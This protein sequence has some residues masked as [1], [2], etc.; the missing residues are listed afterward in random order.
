ME[1][2]KEYENIIKRYINLAKKTKNTESE[3]FWT[4]A[5]SSLKRKDNSVSGVIDSLKDILSVLEISD[6]ESPL[7]TLSLLLELG[8]SSLIIGDESLSK[9]CFEISSKISSEKL[10]K[11]LDENARLYQ[12]KGEKKVSLKI[13][14]LNLDSV[15]KRGDGLK[16]SEILLKM[17]DLH[18]EINELNLSILCSMQAALYLHLWGFPEKSVKILYNLGEKLLGTNNFGESIKVFENLLKNYPIDED[19]KIKI[20]IK[21]SDCYKNLRNIKKSLFFLNNAL[22]IARAEGNIKD[23]ISILNKFYELY[24]GENK[25]KEAEYFKK[26]IEELREIE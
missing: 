26:I 18:E 16:A 14:F 13:L 12:E 2:Y 5:L 7:F 8:L 11:F 17:A 4:L 10:E 15:I 3:A 1:D 19:L 22:K 9:K 20:F 6:K 23:E 25:K 21:I 24:L